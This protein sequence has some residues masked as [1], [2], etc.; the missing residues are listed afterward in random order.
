M[1]RLCRPAGYS[2]SIA[3]SASPGRLLLGVL[4]RAA[5]ALAHLR[6]VDQRRAR[7]PPLVGRAF[8]LEH[9]VAHLPLPARQRLLE[10]GLVVDVLGRRVLDPLG[11]R[12]D[13]R[14]LDLLE[15]V[16]EEERRERGLEQ[17]GEDVPVAR[18]LLQL[19]VRQ[20]A[21]SLAQHRAEI[22]LPRHPRTALPRDDV[23]ADLREPALAEVRIALVQRPR[24]RELEDTVA[25]ELEPLV[26]GRAVGRPGRVR[27]HVLQ[28]RSGQ[29]VDQLAERLRP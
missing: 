13:D 6:A 17:G 29:R 19:L 7:E 11:E 18:Q 16:L 4:L 10:L 28:P 9:R 27:E 1:G 3:A 23:R 8:D 2:A 12:G 5:G 24:D 20:R 22:E 21:A 15:P 25:E 14:G 26:R